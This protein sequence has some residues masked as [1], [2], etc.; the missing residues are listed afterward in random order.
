MDLCRWFLTGG[1]I[2][3]IR[4][5]ECFIEVARHKNFSKAAEIMY[6]SQPSISR[7]IKEL[8]GQF[9][10]TLLYRDTKSVELTD[11][12]EIILKQAQEIVSAYQNIT[13]QLGGLQKMQ[14]GKIYIG[15]PPI[16]AIATFSHLLSAFRQEYP[17]I[18]IKLYEFGPKK[19]EAAV[20][21]GLLDI[22]VFTPAESDELY[23]KI[24]FEQDPLEVIMHPTNLLA[25][26]NSIDYEMLGTEQFILFNDDY[27]L[28][29]LI[30]ESCKK[31]GVKPKI[32]LETSQREWMIQMV[33][34]NL[35]IAILPRRI[36][37][38]LDTNAI[39]S[40]PLVNP[41]LYL[42]LAL[43]WKKNRYLSYAAREFLMFA[44][45][46]ME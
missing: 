18:H 44:K 5:L 24:W 22:G 23:D 35:G 1:I 25:Q 4:N 12:G 15:L 41:Q 7:A 20:Q 3:D 31:V 26:N 27:K 14:I 29:D 8:E 21:D 42:R 30:I 40:R 33:A 13:A 6:I 37:E 39:I 36:C 43:V 34:D 11:A 46:N 19:V 17:N 10:V 28:H 32:V 45:K 2:L 9:G 38:T 16:T